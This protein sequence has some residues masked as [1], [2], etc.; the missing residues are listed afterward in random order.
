MAP[1]GVGRASSA[2]ATTSA[3][4]SGRCFARRRPRARVQVAAAASATK[5]TADELKLELLRIGCK[6]DRGQLLF[7]PKVYG[8]DQYNAEKLADIKR[9]VA[10][11]QALEDEE[12][13][14]RAALQD[15]DWELVLATA[16]L[17]RCSPFFIAISEAF[18]GKTWHAP[19]SDPSTAV[20]SGSLFFRLHE[21]QVM[22][23]GASTIGRVTQTVDSE[24][25]LLSSTFDTILFRLTVIPIVGWFKLLPTFGGR[26]SSYAT[27]LET[28]EQPD[29]LMEMR[30]EL[31]KTSVDQVEGIPKPPFFLS[32]LLGKDFPV[33]SV[34]KLLP[35]NKG[36]A[37]MCTSYLVYVDKDLR[38]CQDKEGCYFIYTRI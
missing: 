38:V 10:E 18:E 6:T 4:G 12:A 8:M 22:S 15:G 25:N 27:S 21:L 16:Q 13:K 3:S 20:P 32:W 2:S 24:N 19:W 36:R 33:N 5:A 11:L 1:Q 23:W 26:V 9:I 7:T 35:W 31:E 28:E 17:F 34:W 37:P 29:G 30:F 14:S